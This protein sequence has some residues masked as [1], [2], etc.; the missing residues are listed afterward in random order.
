MP[1]QV[2]NI[3][4]HGKLKTNYTKKYFPKIKTK[5]FLNNT[6]IINQ[7]KSLTITLV[8]NINCFIFG[9]LNDYLLRFLQKYYAKLKITH[10]RVKLVSINSNSSVIADQT[11][12]LNDLVPRLRSQFGEFT[13][14]EFMQEANVS[15]PASNIDLYINRE[16]R[17]PFIS[18]K[19]KLLQGKAFFKFQFKGKYAKFSLIY[20]HF[21]AKTRELIDV[22]DAYEVEK[23]KKWRID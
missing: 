20:K 2:N 21:T 23:F 15:H 9:N 14:L 6:L 18:M 1:I 16:D 8:H 17:F 11:V 13:H 22:L 3:L 12:I 5:I 7:N 19:F 10:V 4:A